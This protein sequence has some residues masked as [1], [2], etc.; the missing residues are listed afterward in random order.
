MINMSD[1]N[2][3]NN[4]HFN[5]V[6]CNVVLFIKIIF[7]KN[8]FFNNYKNSLTLHHESNKLYYCKLLYELGNWNSDQIIIFF[9]FNISIL[10]LKQTH[11]IINLSDKN[12]IKK[13]VE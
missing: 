12:T 1:R 8:N 10:N 7:N 5:V 3:F 9:I 4:Y 13:R 2:M 11:K 6:F